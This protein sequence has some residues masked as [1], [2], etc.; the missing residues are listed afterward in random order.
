MPQ[1]RQ[2]STVRMPVANILASTMRPLPCSISV[3]ATPREPSS[4]ASA[5]PTGPPPTMR[6]GTTRRSELERLAVEV[7]GT[8]DAN[9]HRVALLLRVAVLLRLDEPLP[10]AVVHLA[11]L[12]DLGGTVEARHPA[13]RQDAGLAQLGLSQE[14]RDLGAVRELLVGRTLAALPE[15]K[16]LLVIDHRAAAR[17]DLRI[18]VRL[19]RADKRNVGWKG[20]IDVIVQDLR[21]HASSRRTRAAPSA[22]DFS[23]AKAISRLR[24]FMPQSGATT[25]RSAATCG[26]ARRIRCATSSGVST[27]SVERSMTPSITV[28]PES[29]LRIERSM[30]GC[31]ASMET[32]DAAL[33][34]SC[35]RKE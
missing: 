17:A 32:C 31:A 21:N 1:R 22:R 10:H 26:R 7:L 16:V 19:H 6:T 24:Y 33:S 5:R 11:G 34:A 25:R 30:R 13:L 35:G 4:I 15:R 9:Q 28:F 2:N 14:H 12:V 18:A 27:A 23:L 29:S 3:Q 20:G 8:L